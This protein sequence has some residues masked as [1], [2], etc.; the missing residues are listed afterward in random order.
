MSIYVNLALLLDTCKDIHFEPDNPSHIGR[1]TSVAPK[2]SVG[3][4][5]LPAASLSILLE[6]PNYPSYTNKISFMCLNRN[7]IQYL[8]FAVAI[9]QPHRTNKMCSKREC[10]LLIRAGDERVEFSN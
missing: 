7:N 2:V 8:P 6:D 3:F 4:V 10:Y 5:Q 9:L 1:N